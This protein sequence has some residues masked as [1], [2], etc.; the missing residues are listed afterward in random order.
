[1]AYGNWVQGKIVKHYNQY[2][3]F[4]AEVCYDKVAETDEHVKIRTKVRIGCANASGYSTYWVHGYYL[5]ASGSWVD[6]T[7]EAHV[8]GNEGITLYAGTSGAYAYSQAFESWDITFYKGKAARTIYVG[9]KGQLIGQTSEAS[10]ASVGINVAARPSYTVS[11]SPGANVGDATGMPQSMTV[12]HNLAEALPT[13]TPSRPGYRFSGWALG[14]TVYQPGASITVTQSAQL[15]AQWQLVANPPSI[16]NALTQRASDTS[17]T[18]D[19]EGTYANFMVWCKP[20]ATDGSTPSIASAQAYYKAHGASSWVGPLAL[21]YW[22]TDNGYLVYGAL[23]QGDGGVSAGFRADTTYDVLYLVV[24]SN[25]VYTSVVDLISKGNP[26]VLDISAGGLGLF[27]EAED[28][29]VKSAYPFVRTNDT[30]YVY[31]ED[32]NDEHYARFRCRNGSVIANLYY[33]DRNSSRPGGDFTAGWHDLGALEY[34]GVSYAP[35]GRVVSQ[36]SGSAYLLAA[37][38]SNGQT[39]HLWLY[40][41]ESTGYISISLPYFIE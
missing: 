30:P 14:G 21:A 41:S 1:M 11:F 9:V 8:T 4:R 24:D 10:T 13:T 3:Q 17:G 15:V 29:K 34:G 33:D 26:G 37:P 5:G 2:R 31:L 40:L 20:E 6:W 32:G 16:G 27:V 38:D 7:E 25:G 28:G 36:S 18:V 39:G 23:G 35:I 19:P 12:Y 22:G